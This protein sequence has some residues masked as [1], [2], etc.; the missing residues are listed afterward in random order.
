M[1]QDAYLETEVLS[2]SPVQLVNMLY[3]GALDSLR[4][5]LVAL[6]RGDISERSRRLSHAEAILGELTVSLDRT[7]GGD[8]SRDLSEL[9][10]Y[11][12]RRIAQ[13]N[14]EQ[15]R[16]PIEE[17][18]GLLST[19]LEAWAEIAESPSVA[20]AAS[21]AYSTGGAGLAGG[22]V[23]GRRSA[24]GGSVWALDDAAA[25]QN[26]GQFPGV[27]FERSRLDRVG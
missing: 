8:L 15:T 22:S 26:L 1:Y 20:A 10:D 17:V 25:D 12:Q 16:A 27:D 5:A 3:R 19:L 24:A 9:Y 23:A 4:S 21:G 11:M 7:R 6:E 2:A 18:C 13:A 14:F